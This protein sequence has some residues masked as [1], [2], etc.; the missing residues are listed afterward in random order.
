MYAKNEI[1]INNL[2]NEII[3]YY[4]KI[5][6]FTLEEINIPIS[7]N[8]KKEYE[9]RQLRESKCNFLNFEYPQRSQ[10]SHDFLVNSKKIQ[11]KVS[12][13]EKK[14]NY[15]FCSMHKHNY[16]FYKLNDNDFYWLHYPDKIHFLLIPAKEML[17]PGT[18][19]ILASIYFANTKW[20]KYKFNYNN[21][22][23]NKIY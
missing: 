12:R 23:L 10:L 9:F 2:S 22:L 8:Q 6:K 1:T 21:I 4:N 3:K 20:L 14:Y 18:D 15:I 11:E 16:K 19:D 5:P 7:K 13:I 17:Q